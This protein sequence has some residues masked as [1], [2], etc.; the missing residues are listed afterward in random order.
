VVLNEMRRLTEETRPKALVDIKLS[1]P[2]LHYSL[3]P[4]PIAVVMTAY[5]VCS[6]SIDRHAQLKA[7]QLFGMAAAWNEW[8]TEFSAQQKPVIPTLQALVPE[9]WVD[10][11]IAANSQ[12]VRRVH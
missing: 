2:T 8:R 6:M 3:N 1:I 4:W 11:L 5:G 10:R 9:V 7:L 12:I